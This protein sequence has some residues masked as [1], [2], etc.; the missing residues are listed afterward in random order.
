MKIL[1]QVLQPGAS[2]A[3][4]ADRH[5]VARALVYQWLRQVREGRLPGLSLKSAATA[6]FA[7]VR[8][9]PEARGT[10]NVPQ[11]GFG[12]RPEN[13]PGPPSLPPPTPSAEPARSSALPARRRNSSVEIKL[14][15]GRVMKIDEGIEPD[16]LARLLAALDGERS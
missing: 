15:N 13:A 5:G 7:A 16:A 3:A 4:V 1:D 12:S 8:V 6:T 14:A 2:V 11:P 10:P 9:V